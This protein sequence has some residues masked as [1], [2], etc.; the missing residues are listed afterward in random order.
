MERLNLPPAKLNM[1]QENGR[2]KVFDVIRKKFVALIPE[3]WVRQHLIH[4]F[5]NE[6][7]YPSGLMA[8]EKI[9]KINGMNKR[10]DIVVYNKK[11]LPVMI[12]E[13]KAPDVA[14][15]NSVFE[16]AARYNM[17]LGVG[18]LLVTNGLKH[19]CAR[20][21]K[22]GGGYKMLKTMPLYDELSM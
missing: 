18:H 12:V 4:Y 3:E 9:V 6:L 21:S 15:D 22:K 10:A 1:K 2:T 8:V 17:K 14:V 7:Q 11:G 13:C 20:L 5:I 19:Y 16:Q